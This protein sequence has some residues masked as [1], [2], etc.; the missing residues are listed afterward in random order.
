MVDGAGPTPIEADG[1]VGGTRA[2]GERRLPVK[3]T[4]IGGTLVNTLPG[5]EAHGE[6]C[7]RLRG[8][9]TILIHAVETQGT[10]RGD[11]RMPVKAEGA[12][13][14]A[15][16]IPRPHQQHTHGRIHRRSS[17]VTVSI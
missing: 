17:V 13:L 14:V 1:T 10:M 3:T 2:G 11:G 6:R 16:R 5:I 15:R 9:R 4:V 7:R 8:G 12:G